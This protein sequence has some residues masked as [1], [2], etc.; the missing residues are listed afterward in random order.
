[1][2]GIYG[3]IFPR[4]AKDQLVK[5]KYREKFIQLSV[6]NSKRGED[7]TGV[8][9]ITR[10][11]ELR[12][13]KRSKPIWNNMFH[14]DW[15]KTTSVDEETVAL[16]GHNRERSSKS[17]SNS[18]EFAHPHIV[19]NIV[20]VHNGTLTNFTDIY[21]DETHDSIALF[22][23]INEN[24]PNKL[25]K[26]V[27]SAAVCY[28]NFRKNPNVFY[29]IS[30]ERPLNYVVE[31]G[32]LVF[33][34]ET[35]HLR[36]VLDTK[37]KIW[38]LKSGFLMRVNANKNLKTRFYPIPEVAKF[39]TYTPPSSSVSS[40]ITTAPNTTN[41]VVDDDDEINWYCGWNNGMGS[42]T[43]QHHLP[44]DTRHNYGHKPYPST[45]EH[46]CDVC[47]KSLYQT[48]VLVF[49][50]NGKYKRKQCLS[51]K[52]DKCTVCNVITCYNQE[53]IM[54]E[55]DSI[56]TCK[57]CYLE[58]MN[59]KLLK[60]CSPEEKDICS[61]CSSEMPLNCMEMIYVPKTK[62]SLPEFKFICFNCLIEKDKKKK[63]KEKEEV[64]ISVDLF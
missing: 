32:V 64:L 24:G 57:K 27:G 60:T 18:A 59:E 13:F 29:F 23:Y 54:I 35:E 63:S 39:K 62:D 7:A 34:S 6:A 47:N 40:G 12:L 45:P 30:C 3:V 36:S 9:R 4:S 43:N 37:S 26:L 53:N 52:P 19:G 1:M 48:I 21:E 51:C 8:F 42:S 14:P 16:I 46:S 28:V 58:K 2:C 33:S 20:G 22:R 15:V 50:E 38:V 44:T 17:W 11:K 49:S 31:N 10:N 61:T 55:K 5:E 25:D 56:M 41:T